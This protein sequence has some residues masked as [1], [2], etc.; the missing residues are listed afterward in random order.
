[1][2]ILQ[3]LFPK[4]LATCLLADN[5]RKFSLKLL[6][7]HWPR[8]VLTLTELMEACPR[9]RHYFKRFSSN[10]VRQEGLGCYS[11]VLINVVTGCVD[12]GYTV[13]ATFHNVYLGSRVYLMLLNIL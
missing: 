4:L 13:L 11:A 7:K 12:R 5:P 6:L 2:S 9:F 1:M 10:Q 8:S 3:A